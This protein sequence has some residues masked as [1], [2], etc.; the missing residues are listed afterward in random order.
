M[1]VKQTRASTTERRTKRQDRN[2]KINLVESSLELDGQPKFFLE[3]I[4]AH[5]H[6]RASI[7]NPH[8]HLQKKLKPK[9]KKSLFSFFEKSSTIQQLQQKKYFFEYIEDIIDLER[10]IVDGEANISSRE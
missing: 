6:Q 7:W 9:P 3:F 8:K 5:F 2:R 10:T 4:G 1:K